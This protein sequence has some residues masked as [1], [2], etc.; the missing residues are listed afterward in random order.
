M[1]GHSPVLCIIY[2][3]PMHSN[4]I[5]LKYKSFVDLGVGG[6]GPSAPTPVPSR[7]SDL[8][9]RDMLK[10]IQA[11]TIAVLKGIIM[12]VLARFWK[13]PDVGAGC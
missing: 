6:I 5:F 13:F 9:T 3:F 10:Y 2:F 11:H 7:Q 4:T 12:K 8:E 1:F